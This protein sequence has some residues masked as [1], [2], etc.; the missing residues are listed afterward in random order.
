MP[1]RHAYDS[2]PA[3][4]WTADPQGLLNY[5]NAVTE[6]YMGVPA[7]DLHGT[8][9]GDA[10]HPQDLAAALPRARLLA[11]RPG[12]GDPWVHELDAFSAFDVTTSGRSVPLTHAV[13]ALGSEQYSFH[14]AVEAVERALPAGVAT[15]WQIGETECRDGVRRNRW[16]TAAEMSTAMAAADVVITHGGAGSVLTA[17]SAGKVP[18]VLPR[19]TD[20]GEHVD[21]HQVRMVASLAAR[22]LVIE[23]RP[24]DLSSEHLETAAA[25]GVDRRGR[26]A[27]LTTATRIVA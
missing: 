12:W 14:R 24:E 2:I 17:L 7:E 4:I 23:A 13:V 8:G 9:W 21:D 6:A 18:V 15:T 3:Q 19:R 16:L 22:G 20:Q 27:P 26:P 25:L 10:V 11:P 1:Y 5:V